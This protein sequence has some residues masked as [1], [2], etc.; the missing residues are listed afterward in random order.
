ME[1]ALHIFKKIL[2]FLLGGIIGILISWFRLFDGLFFFANW[3]IIASIPVS[4][5][6]GV[7]IHELGHLIFGLLTGYSFSSFRV[8]MFIWYKEDEK[9]RFSISKSL[10]AGQCLMVP[11]KDFR[12]FKFVLYNLGG[13]IFDGIF[14]VLLLTLFFVTSYTLSVIFLLGA[15][16]NLLLV[17]QNI[18]PI[19]SIAN[20]GANIWEALKLKNKD[21]ARGLY[22]ML[23]VNHLTMQGQRY[24]DMDSSL[25]ELSDNADPSNYLV[26]YLY[27][28]KAQHV[29]DLGRSTEAFDIYNKLSAYKKL[30]KIYINLINANLLY[31]YIFDNPDHEKAI[32][33]FQNSALREFMKSGVSV[34][35]LILA[36][37]MFFVEDKKDEAIKIFEKG[38]ADLQRIPNKGERIMTEDEYNKIEAL[39]KGEIQ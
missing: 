9:I 19:R 16:I 4:I 25:F 21:A 3:V 28:L 24:R 11:V 27:L 35:T 23:Y 22:T 15:F 17:F 38:K 26:A 20:D 10:V 29:E 39:M 6:L 8:G 18:I 32:A 1:K 30:P 7:I 31:Y 14:A 36:G 37:Y 34:C 33:L 5:L 12:E 2:P 13:V